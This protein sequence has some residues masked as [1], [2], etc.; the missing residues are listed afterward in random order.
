M[1]EHNMIP[2]GHG[3]SGGPGPMPRCPECFTVIDT[4]IAA[5]T[6]GDK[7]RCPTHGLVTPAYGEREALRLRKMMRRRDEAEAARTRPDYDP[8]ID[9]PERYT[10]G[11]ILICSGSSSTR[12]APSSGTAY[13]DAVAASWCALRPAPTQLTW[14]E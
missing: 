7:G 9:Y 5:G 12:I 14:S 13:T 6:R 2:P 4:R 11:P 10:D 8:R 1:S 3:E